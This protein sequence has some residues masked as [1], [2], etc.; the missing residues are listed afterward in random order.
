MGTPVDIALIGLA[1]GGTAASVYSS[2]RARKAQKRARRAQSR[3]EATRARK[4]KM[5]QLRASQKARA[6][7]AAG[8]A[9][10]GTLGTSAFEGGVSSIQQQAANNISF[11]EQIQS[12]QEAIARRMEEADKFRFQ[13][14][15]FAALAST[16][17]SMSGYVSSKP[18]TDPGSAGSGSA[19]GSKPFISA[20]PSGTGR[21][22]IY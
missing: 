11:I 22:S 17:S 13:A 15:A 7:V 14:Q 8:A 4:E 5:Q 18:S 9:A 19:G 3:I 6:E 16:A 2:N 21:G 10:T 20:G 12:G 1:A